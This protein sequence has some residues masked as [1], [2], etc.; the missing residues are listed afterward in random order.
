MVSDTTGSSVYHLLCS[1]QNQVFG[2][3]D[4]FRLLFSM[5]F[6]NVR[7]RT[8]S[9]SRYLSMTFPDRET[10]NQS[11]DINGMAEDLS[12]SW[13]LGPGYELE[14]IVLVIIGACGIFEIRAIYFMISQVYSR[15]FD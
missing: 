12:K 1:K 10:I 6:H 7:Y 2:I 8:Y 3:C 14:F 5:K 15:Q 4:E 13:L 11:N 9:Y